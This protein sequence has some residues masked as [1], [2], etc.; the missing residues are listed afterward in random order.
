M[1]IWFTISIFSVV[2]ILLRSRVP[3]TLFIFFSQ[4]I[5]IVED[6]DSKP[7]PGEEKLGAL[8]AGER[9]CKLYYFSKTDAILICGSKN[10][11]DLFSQVKWMV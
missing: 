10:L 1:F 9:Y 11:L 6:F 4:L 5:K 2:Q 3:E 8:T 7:F